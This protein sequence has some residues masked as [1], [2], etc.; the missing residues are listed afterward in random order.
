MNR[1]ARTILVV[2]LA[3]VP[4]L[5]AT[6]AQA[7][8]KME[9]SAQDDGVFLYQQHSNREAAFRH[10]RTLGVSR[11]RVNVLWHQTMS[12][13]QRNA[14]KKPRT[15]AYNFGIWED[16]IAR[17]KA[18]GIKVHLNLTGE[19]PRWACGNKKVPGKCNGNRPNTKEFRKFT[20]VVAKNFG[21]T[22]DRYSI[23]NE[24]NWYTWLSPH[25]DA[26]LIYR[27]LYRAGYAG[28]KKGNK[29]AKVL[30]GETAPYFQKRKAQ[31]PL[32]FIREMFCVNKRFKKVS[33]KCKGKAL[34]MDGYAH[35]PYDFQVAPTKRRKGADNVTMANLPALTATLDKLRKKG[36]IKG[37]KLAPVYLTEH[38]YFVSGSR[39]IAEK[40]RAKYTVKS[41]EMAQK[42]K[43]IKAQLYYILIS[44]PADSASAF[45]DLGLISQ[46]GVLT[47]TFKALAKWV[48]RAASSGKVAKPRRCSAC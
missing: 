37:P 18:Y 15:V 28:V 40:K 29:R 20:Q 16:V 42:N 1:I 31:A 23:W 44:P 22:V 47:R 48:D 30:M 6:P 26:P 8:K 35:H 38:G 14:K 32:E 24:P 45:F 9:V 46:A 33:K 43:R 27:E 36:F 2:A 19:P 39:R 12:E 13:Q 25:K 34:K 5:A 4:A 17:A 41:F 10:L 11:L 21:R 3:L 7:A